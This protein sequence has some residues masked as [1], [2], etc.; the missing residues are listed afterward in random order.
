MRCS[1][2]ISNLKLS[3][4]VLSRFGIN[5]DLEKLE[6][7]LENSEHSELIEECAMR[8]K[9][10]WE[11][12][13]VISDPFFDTVTDEPCFTAIP[14]V[15]LKKSSLMVLESETLTVLPTTLQKPMPHFKLPNATVG[16]S[17]QELLNWTSTTAITVFAI[18]GLDDLGLSYLQAANTVCGEPEKAGEHALTIS[19]QHD[20]DPLQT[21]QTATVCL[22]INSDPKSLWKNISS[23]PNQLFWKADS[24]YQGKVGHSEWKLA[25]ASKRGRS[26]AHIGSCRDDDFALHVD[27]ESRWHIMAVADGAGS[28]EYS[29]KGAQ[30][31]VQNSVEVLTAHLKHINVGLDT[32]I[33][34]WQLDKTPDNEA[35]IEQVLVNVFNEVLSTSIETIST[36]AKQQQRLYRDFYSTLLIVAH[37]SFPQG[38][39]IIAYWIG[40]GGLGLYIAGESV[41]LMGVGDSGEY[42][43]QTRF[44]DINALAR[45]DLS[46]RL[47]IS[48]EKNFTALVLMTD[49]ITDPLF[50]TDNNLRD[51]SYWDAF[52]QQIE[53]QLEANPEVSAKNLS[54]WLNF[55]SSGNHDDRTIALI[56]R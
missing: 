7:F 5:P 18:N 8:I 47:H 21:M 22:V 31:L 20:D 44:L 27:S 49:G 28:S 1:L 12:F 38:E 56:Y 25:A 32:L 48:S 26:H 37:K 19:Y 42:A 33:E 51:V 36:T 46:K 11:S 15:D 6:H 13:N 53:P 16:K 55:W 43:G 34:G 4:E 17:Y 45:E 50:E 14:V 35:A 41:E 40:D 3:L 39:F 54:D 24:D 30:I 52:W 2:Y 10:A 29:R 23:D 9:Q